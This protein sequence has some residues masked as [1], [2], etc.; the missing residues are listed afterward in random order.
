MTLVVVLVGSAL[1]G[2]FVVRRLL[3]YVRS[4]PGVSDDY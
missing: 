2:V 3:A 1:L 4:M